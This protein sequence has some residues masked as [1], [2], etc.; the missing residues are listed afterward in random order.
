MS[1]KKTHDEYL[2]ELK[3]KNILVKPLENYINAMKKINHK[4]ICGNEWFTSPNTVLSGRTCGCSRTPSLQKYKDR[5]LAKNI[6]V[7]PLGNYVDDNTKILHKCT[8][9]NEWEVTPKLVLNNSHCGCKKI[10]INR[11][12]YRNKKTILYIIKIDNLY[13]IGITTRNIKVRY[14]NECTNYD[15]IYEQK[16]NNGIEAWDIEKYFKE[17][18]ES[19]KYIGK[20]IFKVTGNTEIFTENPLFFKSSI[21]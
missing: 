12:F 5:L 9:G 17:N 14:R 2:L 8:C 18:Y 4:C 13:K 7:K 21:L 3:R 15:I 11:G 10:D 19:K 16:F 6:L 20:Q 1:K